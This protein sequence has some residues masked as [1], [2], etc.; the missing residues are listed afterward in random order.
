MAT[1][2]QL[3]EQIA[4]GRWDGPLAALYGTAPQE[5]ARQRARYCA[6]RLKIDT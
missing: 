1:S 5:L 2:A 4:A 6:A 3:R